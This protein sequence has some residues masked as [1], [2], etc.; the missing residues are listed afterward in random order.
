MSEKNNLLSIVNDNSKIE[1]QS[2]KRTSHYMMDSPSVTFNHSHLSFSASAYRK[3]GFEK[4]KHCSIQI[5]TG[6]GPEEA[7]ALYLTPNNEPASE[8]NCPIKVNDRKTNFA[9]TCFGTIAKQIPKVVRLLKKPR[10]QRR[11][12]TFFD[13]KAK[14]W[15]IPLEPCFEYRNRDF[16]NLVDAKAVYRLLFKGN[17]EYIGQSSQLNRRINQHLKEGLIKFDTVEYSV[18]NNVSDDRRREYEAKFLKEFVEENGLLPPHNRIMGVQ[19]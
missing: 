17:V 1:L 16:K 14:R 4:Y 2:L 6:I 15:K 19:H 5:E 12:F 3:M 10:N 7:L 11:I 9:I 18:L 13:K 8:S